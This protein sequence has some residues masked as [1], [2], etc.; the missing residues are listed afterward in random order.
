[1]NNKMSISIN[2]TVGKKMNDYILT[3]L[4]FNSLTFNN[5]TELTGLN[6]FFIL[7][8]LH[9]VS[10]IGIFRL[11]HFKAFLKPLVV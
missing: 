2:Q 10:K 1:M 5:L 3:D 8:L 6:T 9:T 4:S 11:I 7:T